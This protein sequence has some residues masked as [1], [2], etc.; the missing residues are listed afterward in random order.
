MPD[1]PKI[2]LK[3]DAL[4]LYATDTE[5]A[6]AILGSRAKSWKGF[7]ALYEGKGLPKVNELMGGRFV[8]AVLKFFDH[9]EGVTS[10]APIPAR[11]GSEDPSSWSSRKPRGRPGNR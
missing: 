7:A 9:Y 5:L 8:P 1:A 6:K 2:P 10:G 4:P 11:D 3:I